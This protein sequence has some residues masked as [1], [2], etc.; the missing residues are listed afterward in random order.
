MKQ[1]QRPDW[2]GRIVVCLASGP[3]LT[4]E[5]CERVRESRHPVAVT[6]TTFRLAPWADVVFG[7]DMAWWKQ[8]GKEVAEACS[9][10]K[11]STSHAARAFGAESLWQCSWFPQLGASNS[12]C[13]VVALAIVSGASRIVLLGYDCQRTGGRAHWHADH[14]KP[15]GN[16]AS[17]K[18]WPR[19]FEHL[20]KDAQR[21]GCQ[22]LNASRE[23][24]IKCFERVDL[25]AAL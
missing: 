4:A 18:R 21:A 9:G 22:V 5:D 1:V 3:S 24:A 12:G 6:N 23:T 17:L 20:A 13:A 14:P 11:F 8:Y 15:M 16:A 2:A 10:R 25:E 7:M 19:H